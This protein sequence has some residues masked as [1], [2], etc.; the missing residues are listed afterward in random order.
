MTD[1]LIPA[2]KHLKPPHWRSRIG[3]DQV[4]ITPK[5]KNGNCVCVVIVD[6]FSKHTGIYPFA[7]YTAETVATALFQYFCAYGVFDEIISDPGSAIMADVVTQLNSWLGIKHKVSLVDRHESNGVEGTNKKLLAHLRMLVHDESIMN[8]WSDPTVLPLI[9]YA[10]NDAINSETGIRPF[11]AKFGMDDSKYMKLPDEVQPEVVTNEWVQALTENLRVVRDISKKYQD[12]LI[13]KREENSPGEMQNVYQ[14]GD[15]VLFELEKQHPRASKLSSP[16]SGPYEVLYQRGNDVTCKHLSDMVVKVFHVERLKLFVGSRDDA[17]KAAML[18]SDQYLID[19]FLGYRGDF[20]YRTSLEFKI[21]FMDG[22]ERWLP[23]SK[24]VTE[25]HQFQYFCE[26][27]PHL[28]PLLTTAQR[29]NQVNGVRLN[30][31]LLLMY[32]LVMLLLCLC[33]SSVM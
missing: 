19:K 1:F 15:F 14:P 13:A 24:D 4:T 25:T 3:V 8:R 32:N 27:R 28:V 29:A 16:F 6:H 12:E 5:D 2:V 11:D 7:E 9:N 30:V 33:N 17:M 26:A 18:D 23:W 31:N 20:R 22:D 21:R 10:L